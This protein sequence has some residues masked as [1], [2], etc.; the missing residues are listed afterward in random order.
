MDDSTDSRSDN[1]IAQDT[2]DIANGDDDYEDANFSASESEK[3]SSYVMHNGKLMH[4]GVHLKICEKTKVKS[5]NF[6]MDQV[7]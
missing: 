1:E 6:A 7:K 3:E 4:K 2:L 5:T